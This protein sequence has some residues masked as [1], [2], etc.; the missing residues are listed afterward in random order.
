MRGGAPRRLNRVRRFKQGFEHSEVVS[1]QRIDK[2]LWFA[3]VVKTRSL[4]AKLVEGGH[5]RINGVRSDNAAKVLR[6]GDVLTIALERQVRVLR[7]IGD[8]ERRG[9]FSE[10]SLLFEELGLPAGGTMS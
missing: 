10:A 9:P 3:R 8:G 4:A 1:P 6:P 7:V 2:W 5:V